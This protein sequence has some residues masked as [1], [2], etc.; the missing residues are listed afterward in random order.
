MTP[1]AKIIEALLFL[2]PE[3][4]SLDDLRGVGE[5]VDRDRL[6]REEQQRLERAG[7]RAH[8]AC[9]RAGTAVARTVMGP[10]GSS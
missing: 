7:E 2:S 8:A 1:L 9:S 3:P 4:V 5:L 6:G 10:N